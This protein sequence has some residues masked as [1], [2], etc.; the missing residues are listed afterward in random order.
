MT[1]L[2]PGRSASLVPHWLPYLLCGEYNQQVGVPFHTDTPQ[3]WAKYRNAVQMDRVLINHTHWCQTTDERP[4]QTISV[5][6]PVERDDVKI[7]KIVPFELSLNCNS[8]KLPH[9]SMINGTRKEEGASYTFQWRGPEW[10][11][12]AVFECE[13]AGNKQEASFVRTLS[14]LLEKHEHNVGLNTPH[15]RW[16]T[17]RSPIIECEGSHCVIDATLRHFTATD[18]TILNEKTSLLQK[19]IKNWKW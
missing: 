10:W 4:R 7:A 11:N 9:R 3:Q 6:V 18:S 16:S 8:L 2:R 17:W 14:Q 13:S 5:D 1:S 15:C 19:L 12:L